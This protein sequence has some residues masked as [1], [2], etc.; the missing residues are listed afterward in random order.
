ME[1]FLTSYVLLCCA[2]KAA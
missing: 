1:V 2:K